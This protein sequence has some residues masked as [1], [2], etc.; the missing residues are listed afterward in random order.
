M[1]SQRFGWAGISFV[2]A[3]VVTVMVIMVATEVVNV[4]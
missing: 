4:K 2:V 1:P 3:M